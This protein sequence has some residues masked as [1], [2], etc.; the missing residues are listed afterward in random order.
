MRTLA[1]ND[2]T[3]EGTSLRT[4]NSAKLHMLIIVAHHISSRL[5]VIKFMR[6]HVKNTLLK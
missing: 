5:G 6:F 1:N 4:D 2:D 3:A